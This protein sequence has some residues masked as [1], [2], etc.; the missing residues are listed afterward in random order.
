MAIRAVR[1]DFLPCLRIFQCLWAIFFNSFYRW[2]ILQVAVHAY[3]A[4]LARFRK[5]N[6]VPRT[7]G[8]LGRQIFVIRPLRVLR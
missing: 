2:H 8:T 7:A 5:I 6:K 4:F 3:W 1:T